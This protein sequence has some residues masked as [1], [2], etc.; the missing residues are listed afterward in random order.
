M[1]HCGGAH[2]CNCVVTGDGVSGSGT[3][4]DPYV[5]TSVLEDGDGNLSPAVLAEIGNA[6]AAYFEEGGAPFLATYFPENYGAKGDG[7]TDDQP[8]IQAMYDAIKAS[9]KPALV[10]YRARTYLLHNE[11][12]VK[13]NDTSNLAYGAVFLGGT[14]PT[15]NGGLVTI[16]DR[17][18][19]S[20]TIQR[21]QWHGGTFIPRNAY[22]NGFNVVSAEDVLVTDIHVNGTIAGQRGIA[23]QTAAPY[24]SIKRVS[25]IGCSVNGPALTDSFNLNCNL[26]LPGV[27]CEDISF[28]NIHASGSAMGVRIGCSQLGQTLSRVVVSDAAVDNCRIGIQFNDTTDSSITDVDITNL[29]GSGGAVGRGIDSRLVT[30]GRIA[31]VRASGTSTNSAFSMATGTGLEMSNISATGPFA[32]GLYVGVTDATVRHASFKDCVIG[33]NTTLGTGRSVYRGFTFDGVSTPVN[34]YRASDT[35]VDFV[36]RTGTVTSDIT[37]NSN[38]DTISVPPIGYATTTGFTYNPTNRGM[39]SSGTSGNNLTFRLALAA[40]TYMLRAAHTRGPDRGIYTFKMDG[41]SVGTLDGYSG[42]V[43]DVLQSVT[44]IVV[45]KPSSILTVSM[46]SAN[47][48]SSSYVGDLFDLSLTRTA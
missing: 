42:T 6:A 36:T 44:G 20:R 2:S 31:N 46:E 47:A 17:G 5:I 22:D 34:T 11:V 10:R 12:Q 28:R 21:I 30:R 29:S 15:D 40:G 7:V 48:S 3:L 9:G 4:S 19:S 24:G 26:T 32:I 37:P 39:K 41:I 18:D 45:T 33:L 1:P 14:S 27:V 23:I 38:L 8:S 16:V 35:Y 13:S 25:I 43:N